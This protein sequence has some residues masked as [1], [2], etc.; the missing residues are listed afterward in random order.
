MRMSNVNLDDDILGYVYVFY[1][2]DSMIKDDDSYQYKY[3][4]EIKPVDVITV[5]YGDFSSY[6]EV[7]ENDKVL[8]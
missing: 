7:L 6:Y 1:K 8:K 3:F 2:D 4:K 5:R